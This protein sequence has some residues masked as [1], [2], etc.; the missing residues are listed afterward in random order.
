[1]RRVK[2]YPF[3][4][5]F[6]WLFGGESGMLCVCRRAERRYAAWQNAGLT[7]RGIYGSGLTGDGRAGTSRG[8]TRTGKPSGRT[9][10]AKPR[11]RLRR[12]V[13]PWGHVDGRDSQRSPSISAGDPPQDLRGKCI[14]DTKCNKV[15]TPLPQGFS[16]AEAVNICRVYFSSPSAN[17]SVFFAVASDSAVRSPSS[18]RS[19]VSSTALMATATLTQEAIAFF[20]SAL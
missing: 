5:T 1:M 9:S 13:Q 3:V 12:S 20:E 19:G 2:N 11:R 16:A 7:A 15:R 18:V 10:L 17:V 4:H 14:N 8:M 6:P